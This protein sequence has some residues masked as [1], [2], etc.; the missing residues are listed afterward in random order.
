M[1]FTGSEA[2][3][4]TEDYIAW[5][6]MMFKL[7]GDVEIKTSTEDV[8]D[9]ENI[10]DS[11]FLFP[12]YFNWPSCMSLC[13]KMHQG[14]VPLIKDKKDIAALRNWI[15]KVFVFRRGHRGTLIGLLLKLQ[16]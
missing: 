7:N 3:S 14:R 12:D 8:F 16:F 10:R 11:N 4:Q 13:R 5:D 2:C 15:D 1:E 6:D 9:M